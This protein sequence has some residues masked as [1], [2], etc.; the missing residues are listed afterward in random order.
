MSLWHALVLTVRI[1][2]KSGECHWRSPCGGF[3]YTTWQ[4]RLLTCGVNA[5]LILAKRHSHELWDHMLMKHQLWLAYSTTWTLELQSQ[6]LA[7][8]Q[9]T[10]AGTW[11]SAVQLLMHIWLTCCA[12]VFLIDTVPQTVGDATNNGSTHFTGG[13]FSQLCHALVAVECRVWCTD[14][15]GRVLERTCK[16]DQHTVTPQT[17]HAST[18]LHVLTSASD[19]IKCN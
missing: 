14:D 19:S 11:G 13:H 5:C 1:L 7:N 10:L 2:R 6:A 12:E 3:N 17:T 18:S 15:I 8:T 4:T 9:N 16:Q